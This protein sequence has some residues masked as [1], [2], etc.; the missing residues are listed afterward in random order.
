MHSSFAVLLAAVLILPTLARAQEA[1]PSA[2]E[3]IKAL[4]AR[5]DKLETA[6]ASASQ[7]SF[8]P[9]M[10][11][12]IDMAL[13]STNGKANFNFR[14]AELNVESPIDPY[15]KGWAVI[16]GSNGNNPTTNG[17]TP[18]IDIEEATLET[19]SLPQNFTV[20]G[21]RLFAN[22]GRLA[23]FHDH[24]LPFIDRPNSLNTFVG[25]E[26]R[27]DGLEVQYL[28][29]IDTYVSAT[30]GFYDKVGTSNGRQDVT[31][32][33]SLNEFSYLARV[34][35]Y[36]DIGDNHSLE[37]GLDSIWTPKRTVADTTT[38][39][40]LG[41]VTVRDTWRTLTGLD[42]TYRYQPVQGGLYKG[43]IWGTE[44]MQNN[45]R[46][47]DGSNLPQRR[48]HSYSGFSYVEL[49]SGRHLRGG[50]MADATQDLDNV[51]LL[52]KTGTVFLSYD[53][54]EF[55]RLR[56]AYAQAK[57]NDSRPDNHTIGLQW[58]GVLGH[59]VHG[60]RDR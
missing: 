21:G 2:E 28:F 53:V 60:F 31:G 49:R 19:T 24:E 52:T 46:R 36:K 15:L 42:I 47:F 27:G 23:H 43:V 5:L 9:A 22:F 56:V 57:T 16:T 29:P 11:L 20:R 26:T 3:R 51:K 41:I 4:E 25:G 7:S 8:N 38:P 30:A 50:V 37:M 32:T 35:A 45:E 17:G 13:E 44:L 12:A 14:S 59:H 34:N 39:A 1:A 33:R 10:G 40:P 48:N 54:T 58:T 6:P 55:Q 18:T